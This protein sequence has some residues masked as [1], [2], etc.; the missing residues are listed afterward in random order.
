M[1]LSIYRNV[2]FK[3]GKRLRRNLWFIGIVTFLSIAVLVTYKDL[4]NVFYLND[5]WRMLANTYIHGLTATWYKETITDYPWYLLLLGKTRILSTLINNFILMTFPLNVTPFII[6]FYVTHILNAVLVYILAYVLSKRRSIAIITAFFFAITGSH[7]QSL[8]WV[9]A[10]VQVLLSGMFCFIALLQYLYYLKTKSRSAL[11]FVLFLGYIS[12]LI[13]PTGIFIFPFLFIA[14][15]MSMDKKVLMSW[16]KK[17]FW[18]GIIIIVSAIGMMYRLSVHGFPLLSRSIIGILET[19]IANSIYYPFISLGHYLIQPDLLF[20][21]SKWYLNFQYGMLQNDGN[22]NYLINYVLADMITQ[23][24][25]LLIVASVVYV[26]F[27]WNKM[28]TAIFI[29]GLWYVCTFLPISFHLLQRYSSYIDSRYVYYQSFS[30]GFFIAVVFI[31]IYQNAYKL[32]PKF[33]K[34]IQI[35]LVLS[36]CAF[37]VK[38]IQLTQ[39]EVTVWAQYG[40]EMTAFIK[41]WKNAKLAIPNN[42]IFYIVSDRGYISPSTRLPFMLGDGFVLSVLLYPSGRIPPSDMGDQFLSLYGSQGYREVNGKGYGYFYNMNDLVHA[43]QS[44]TSLRSSQ[45]LAFYYYG[46]KHKIV[47]ITDE[48]KTQLEQ[49]LQE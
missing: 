7:S 6:L 38:Q 2:M 31:Y 40:Q 21:L 19:G 29:T 42:P 39:R 36:L 1:N 11:I 30:V 47:N 25:S 9:G 8:I 27:R 45:L 49:R 12:F 20:R 33:T 3:V 48:I 17:Y 24:I 23:P 34:L 5:E 44:D 41:E 10:G 46:F 18:I 16:F 14:V 37:F 43:Y 4:P 28:R 22:T 35:L 32:L 26:W 15:L 13:R